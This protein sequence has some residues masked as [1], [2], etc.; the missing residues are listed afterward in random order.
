MSA[1][2]EMLDKKVWA[3]VGV[4][5]DRNKFGYKVYKKL[6]KSGYT[7]YAINPKLAELEGDKVY[8]DLA[9]LPEVPDVVNCV[10]PPKVT[11][12]IVSQCAKQGIQYVWMQP[13]ADGREALA[14]AKE[15]N[16]EAQRACVLAQLR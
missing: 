1:V 10:V 13:G 9:S 15:N 2:S 12:D 16:I 11:T 4:S 3:V 8:P 5:A 6:K 7:V 14:L